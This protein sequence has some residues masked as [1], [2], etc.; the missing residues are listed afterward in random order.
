VFAGGKL[1]GV[2]RS[3]AGNVYKLYT[4]NRISVKNHGA[5]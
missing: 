1:K 3:R 2:A 5:G 4:P